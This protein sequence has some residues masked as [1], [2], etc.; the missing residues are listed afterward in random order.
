MPRF[1]SYSC[2]VSIQASKWNRPFHTLFLELKDDVDPEITFWIQKNANTY[3]LEGIPSDILKSL[4]KEMSTYPAALPFLVLRYL[5]MTLTPNMCQFEEITKLNK[6]IKVLDD[7]LRTHVPTTLRLLSGC[8]SEWVAPYLQT[9]HEDHRRATLS[10][11][12]TFLS[13]H[14]LSWI[15]LISLLGCADAG[16]KQLQFLEP[17]LSQMKGTSAD[18]DDIRFIHSVIYD[19]IRFMTYFREPIWDGGLFVHR[20]A[21][22]APT[23]TFIHQTY[24]P[25]N[26]VKSGL[27]ANWSYKFSLT[28]V[29]RLCQTSNYPVLAS[30]HHTIPHRSIKLWSLETGAPLR[31]FELPDDPITSSPDEFL[32]LPSKNHFT[33]LYRDHVSVFEPDHSVKYFKQL[34][35]EGPVCSICYTPDETSLAIRV[36]EGHLHFM[37]LATS[38]IRTYPSFFPRQGEGG[39]LEI[40]PHNGYIATCTSK[41][42]YSS[43]SGHDSY[44]AAVEVYDIA[45]GQ[46]RAVRTLEHSHATKFVI[47]KIIWSE[48][49]SHMITIVQETWDYDSFCCFWDGEADN[50]WKLDIGTYG[51]AGFGDNGLVVLANKTDIRLIHHSTCEVIFAIPLDTW[52][53][54]VFGYHGLVKSF[55]PEGTIFYDISQMSK[56]SLSF[57]TSSPLPRAYQRNIFQ[58]WLKAVKCKLRVEDLELVDGWLV[59][60]PDIKLVWIPFPFEKLVKDESRDQITIS[61]YYESHL[62]LDCK[63]VEK[64]LL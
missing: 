21:F 1:E 61:D 54:K 48:D 32:A 51:S 12:R 60:K 28:G 17:V 55:V 27:D 3:H 50:N 59:M 47:D 24:A 9:L 57:E 8:W 44:G 46:A 62:V 23:S 64:Y 58:N 43:T 42:D 13:S 5:N 37:D 63:A 40:S 39:I 19:S 11:L 15:E 52:S 45:N 14:L 20:L 26:I 7:R 41:L 29:D 53:D 18:T 16:L 49:Q 30:L 36:W 35:L 10:E 6:D 31:T 4:P 34:E 2:F 22:F 25:E 38:G 56:S 33:F